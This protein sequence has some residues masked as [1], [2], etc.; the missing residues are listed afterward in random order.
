MIHSQW[1]LRHMSEMEESGQSLQ[2]PFVGYLVAIAATIQ[3]EFTISKHP[4][5]AAKA[6]RNVEKAR[7][8]LQKMSREWPNMLNT[9]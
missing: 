3:L 7:V 9:V 6:V 1:V 5:V 8:F 4:K 2:D